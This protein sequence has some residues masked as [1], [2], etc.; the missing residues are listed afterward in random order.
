M[1]T[2]KLR[3]GADRR[4]RAG[5]PWIFSNELADSPKGTTPGTEV[6]LQDSKG[7]FLA[8]GYG[9]PHSLIAFRALSFD[10]GESEVCS[11]EY[12]QRKI[13]KA[14]WLRKSLGY[15]QSCRMVYG[16]GDFLPGLVIDLYKIEQNGKRGQALC[17]QVLSAGMAQI[18][19]QPA[20]FFQNLVEEA[21]DNQITEFNWEQTAV[22]LRNDVQVRRLEGLEVE[23]P[24]MIKGID[25]IDLNEVD[26]LMAP[27]VRE[28]SSAVI[29]MATDLIGGQKTGFFLDQ[30]QNIQILCDLLARTKFDEGV[31]RILDLCCYVGQ[32][33]TKIVN[34]LKQKG[35]Q[36]EVTAADASEKALAFAKKNI[37]RQGALCIPKKLDVLKDLGSLP[38]K[39]FDIGIA[40]PPA[41]IKAKKDIPTGRHAYL[42]LNSHAFKLVKSGGLLVSCSCSGLFHEAELIDV[43]AKASRR[44]EAETRC[45]LK[46]GH[47]ADHP[48]LMSFAEGFYLKM[49]VHSV[50]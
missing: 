3:S 25:G 47:G 19:G 28:S 27:A 18:L 8:Y 31:V 21:L 17:V 22:V 37:E 12:V 46:G 4:I 23:A 30:A 7:G 32:W 33:S 15:Q 39:H 45:V 48:V 16:E 29:P 9:N 50:I 41:F 14:W 2:C 34:T 36:V 38:E 42:K 10:R 35:V 24:N 40:D 43:L 20:K 1:V 11:P 44:T 6:Q 26:I 5:H 13:L 49:F